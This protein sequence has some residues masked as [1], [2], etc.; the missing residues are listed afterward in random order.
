MPPLRE[1]Q[2]SIILRTA[3]QQAD[4]RLVAGMAQEIVKRGEINVDLPDERRIEGDRFQF[5]DRVAAQLEVIEEQVEEAVAARECDMDG[6]T[7][8]RTGERGL[9]ALWLAACWR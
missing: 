4:R 7:E 1:R 6:R 9:S 8:P 5:D 2:A 3:P